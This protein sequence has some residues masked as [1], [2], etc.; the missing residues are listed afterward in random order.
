MRPLWQA[1]TLLEEGFNFTALPMLNSNCCLFESTVCWGRLNQWWI[2]TPALMLSIS[3]M[4]PL[5]WVV[6]TLNNEQPSRVWSPR[7]WNLYFNFSRKRCS[8][9]MFCRLNNRLLCMTHCKVDFY[10]FQHF[11]VILNL[12]NLEIVKNFFLS[13]KRT[14]NILWTLFP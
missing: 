4:T 14:V 8:C 10:I 6:Y 2:C 1:L 11:V 12:Y 3:S 13:F 5:G 9:V 7:T